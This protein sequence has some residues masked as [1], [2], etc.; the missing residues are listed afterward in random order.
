[1]PQFLADHQRVDDDWERDD[2]FQELVELA[3]DGIIVHDGD[4]IVLANAAAL[5][6]AGATTREEMVGIAIERFLNPPYLKSVEAQLIDTS[7]ILEPSP[8]TLDTFRRLDG[9]F[10][11]VEVRAAVFMDRGRPAAHLVVHDITERLIDEA[12]ARQVELRLQ[13]AQRMHTIGALAGGVAHEVNNM[14]SVVLGSA[15]FLLHDV[16]MPAECVADVHEIIKAAERASNVTKQLLAFSRRGVHRP[17]PVSVSTLITNATPTLR[18]ILGENRTLVVQNS[19]R[20]SVWADGMQLDQVLINLVMNARDAMPNGGVLTIETSEAKIGPLEAGS[21]G[22]PVLLG[23]YATIRVHDSGI[24]MDAGTQSRIFEPFYTTK[25]IGEGTG[26][27]LAASL[28]ILTQNGARIS[29]ESVAGEGASFTLFL[30]VYG[31]AATPDAESSTPFAVTAAMRG[32]ATI[33]VVDD[34]IAVRKI[35]ARSLERAGF[36]VIQAANGAEALQLIEVNGAPHLVLTDV[37]MPGIG[38]VALARELEHRHPGLPLLFMSGYSATELDHEGVNATKATVVQKPFSPDVVVR[39][40][41]EAL[42]AVRATH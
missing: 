39:R 2:R 32:G 42:A 38:G 35:V 16:R 22:A 14:M 33:L 10:L 30:P 37:M 34:E 41:E 29:V 12:N 36:L 25:P 28:G 13:K 5:R 18:R 24:G 21:V 8:P 17:G 19:S 27:G 4:V 40:V 6:L 20:S 3:P 23:A 31:V 26:L 15:E 11:Q 1:V 9:S 7:T